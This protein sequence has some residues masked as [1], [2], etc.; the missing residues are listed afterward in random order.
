MRI[1]KFGVGDINKN[2]HGT[3]MIIVEYNT[4]DDIVVEFQDEYKYRVHNTCGN[5]RRGEIKN[6]FDRTVYNV[7]YFGV[8]DYSWVN[9]QHIYDTWK[10]ML[11][12]CY[13][14]YKLN[15]A[16]YVEYRDCFVCEEWKNFQIFAEWY[17]DNYYLV[18][19]ELMQLDKDI[20]QSNNKIYS[21]ETCLIVPKRINQLFIGVNRV[22]SDGLPNGC[23]V[24][25]QTKEPYLQVTCNLNGTRYR[26]KVKYRLDQAEEAFM[27]YKRIKEKYIREIAEKYKIYLPKK[28]YDALINFRVL[29]N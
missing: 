8:G 9:N 26:S 2:T 7:G 4:Y 29:R 14:P 5:F 11:R 10:D 13:D 20:L 17:D 24:Q 6:P 25:H 1:R 15:E 28:V 21:P 23:Y 18:P 12:R 27:E 3:D 22:K 16:R 19:G